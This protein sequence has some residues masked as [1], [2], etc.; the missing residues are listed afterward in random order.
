MPQAELSHDVKSGLRG[1]H[2]ISDPCPIHRPLNLLLK[3]PRT[4]GAQRIGTPSCC[5]MLFFKTTLTQMRNDLKHV[6]L[7]D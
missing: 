5:G 6:Q 2:V 4:G 3:Y 7:C 1:R